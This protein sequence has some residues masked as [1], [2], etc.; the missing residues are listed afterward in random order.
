MLLSDISKIIDCER[1]LYFK[2]NKKIKF[3]SSNSKSIIK[4]SIFVCNFKKKIKKIYLEE[5]IKNGVIAII[6]NKNRIF[7]YIF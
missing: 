3:I 1:I 4:N 7:S 2:N 6:T 5:A